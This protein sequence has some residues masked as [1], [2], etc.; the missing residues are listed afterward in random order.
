MGG[1]NRPPLPTFIYRL[2]INELH[3]KNK[4][5]TDITKLMPSFILTVIDTV[6]QGREYT[7][8]GLKIFN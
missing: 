7:K 6:G 5:E 3:I 4:N 8:N 1:Q 2:L